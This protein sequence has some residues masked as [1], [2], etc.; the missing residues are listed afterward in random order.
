[1]A[2]RLSRNRIRQLRLLAQGLE[3]SVAAN[4]AVEVVRRV[5]G[6]QAQDVAA[7]ALAVRARSRGLTVDAVDDAR[8]R[9]RT[10]VRTWAMR[11]T[12]HWLASEDV[13]WIL[14]VLGPPM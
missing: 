13:G 12:L 4:G 8:L 7:A 11:G 6:L 2:L 14:A 3:P 5:C 9:A 1:M 10:I